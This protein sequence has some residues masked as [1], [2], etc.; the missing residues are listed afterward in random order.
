M[1]I[2]DPK[3]EDYKSVFE[4]IKSYVTSNE[5]EIVKEED[6]GM[7]KL[8]YI[9]KKREKGYYYLLE[10]KVEQK[11]LPEIEREIKVDEDIIRYLLT[12]AKNQ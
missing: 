10:A 3:I 6:M 4:R 11:N 7:R 2:I 5:G 8:E 9:V 1:L 12:V